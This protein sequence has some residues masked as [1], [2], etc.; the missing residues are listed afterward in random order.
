MLKTSRRV[1]ALLIS[2]VLVALLLAACGDTATPVPSTTSAAVATTSAA[3]T[4]TAAVATTSAAVATTT[5]ATN[6]TT[7]VATGATT[8]AAVATTTAATNTTTAVATGA[9]TTTASGTT[10]AAGPGSAAAA[11]PSPIPAASTVKLKIGIALQVSIP[12]LVATKDGFIAGM[13][14][15]GFKDGQ[16]VTYDLKDGQNDAPSLQTIG[17][18]FRDEKVDMIYA[19]GTVALIQMY[20][21]NKDTNVP[22]I[23]G[24]I[25]DPYA[26]LPS[27]IKSP[28]DHGN[29]TGSQAYP[30]V[31]QGLQV[32]KQFLPNAK[33][34]G[35]V[36][37]TSEANSKAVVQAIQDGSKSL[38][39]TIDVK[40]ITKADE[41]LSASQSLATDKVDVILAQTDTTVS[42][43]FE[44]MVQ[45]AIQNKIPIIALDVGYGPRG[46]EVSLGLDYFASGV[47]AARAAAQVAG[48]TK[49]TD[50]PIEKLKSVSI[51]VNT[52]AASLI[53]VTIPDA[54]TSQATQKY[55]T[56][57]AP[58]PKK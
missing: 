51:A 36:S 50:V 47:D 35:I 27:V 29:L 58:A 33:K 6:T 10:T 57:Q 3:T 41:V 37:N 23:F 17:Q 16:N 22:I 39:Y 26:A 49:V 14:S 13:A 52:K 18:R 28:T 31:D 53:G 20:N 2:A 30:P 45:V 1:V 19:I 40:G 43:A 8:S 21:T 24:A 44:S 34:V 9:T 11:C 7:A 46:A 15:C 42:N 25:T 12:P 32:L 55:D 38:G 54:I 48:G 4:T 56:I 5:A